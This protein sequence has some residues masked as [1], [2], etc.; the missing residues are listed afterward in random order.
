MRF[1]KAVPGPV[2]VVGGEVKSLAAIQGELQSKPND[3]PAEQNVG[4]DIRR[5]LEQLPAE[6]RPQVEKLLLESG[7]VPK[8]ALPYRQPVAPAPPAE[9]KETQDPAPKPQ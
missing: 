9:P 2:K 6:V 8:G 1:E 3:L 7:V 5:A 4:R